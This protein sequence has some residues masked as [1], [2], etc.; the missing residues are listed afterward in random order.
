[1]AIVDK[2]VR[3]PGWFISAD[4]DWEAFYSY[5]V[6]AREKRE[7]KALETNANVYFAATGEELLI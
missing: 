1:M 4:G 3:V 6:S 5:R 7:R 2:G